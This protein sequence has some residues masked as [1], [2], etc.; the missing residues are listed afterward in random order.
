MKVGFW[1]LVNH[2][3]KGS[4]SPR[5]LCTNDFLLS[6]GA[7]EIK[8]GASPHVHLFLKVFIYWK[9]LKIEID[10]D[11]DLSPND[12]CPLQPKNMKRQMQGLQKGKI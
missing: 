6:G 11:R 8:G 5:D 2:V 3:R 10:W 9:F 1:E 12:H 4:K 7:Y